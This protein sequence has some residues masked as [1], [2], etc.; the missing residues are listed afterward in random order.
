MER[1]KL[2]GQ[3]ADLNV[4]AAQPGQIFDD[5]AEIYPASIAW[6]IF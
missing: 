2:L 4:V 6:I 3:L 5:T 1:K